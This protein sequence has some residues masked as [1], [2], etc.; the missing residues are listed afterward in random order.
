MSLPTETVAVALV[1]LLVAQLLI[2]IAVARWALSWHR[3][4]TLEVIREEMANDGSAFGKHRLDPYA[5]EPLRRQ[6][7][8]DIGEKFDKLADAMRE[9]TAGHRAEMANLATIVAPVIK[10]NGEMMKFVQAQARR[11]SGSHRDEDVQE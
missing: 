6:L 10:Q 5:H 4:S 7:M 8:L 11:G 1:T 2:L 9:Q 3:S